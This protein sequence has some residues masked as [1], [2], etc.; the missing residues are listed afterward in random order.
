MEQQLVD[1]V[2]AIAKKTKEIFSRLM[3]ASYRNFE[4]CS[5]LL[6]V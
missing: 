1:A 2:L 6:G 5:F 4:V 3:K